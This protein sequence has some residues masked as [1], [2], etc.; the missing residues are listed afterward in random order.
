MH[1]CPAIRCTAVP[2]P[3]SGSN[4][5]AGHIP[6]ASSYLLL[7]CTPILRGAS[8]RITEPRVGGTVGRHPPEAKHWHSLHVTA[9]AK[10]FGLSF[11]EAPNLKAIRK[12]SLFRALRRLDRTGNT[13]YRGHRFTL[14]LTDAPSCAPPRCTRP[15]SDGRTQPRIH[16]HVV[17]CRRA[18]QRSLSTVVAMASSPR[19]ALSCCSHTGDPLAP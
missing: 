4:P 6:K 17:E 7:L 10:P 9:T 14:P 5:S 3:K 19:Q 11:N 16:V 15:H 2:G 12:R 18:I 1:H 8:V 13:T